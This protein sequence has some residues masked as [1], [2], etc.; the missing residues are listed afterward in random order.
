V[1]NVQ[2]YLSALF[3]AA[4]LPAFAAP[5]TWI[6]V[7][8]PHFE[9]Y[10]TAG[11]RRGRE[12]VQYFEQVREQF[13]RLRSGHTA[14]RR[15]RI[16][17][18]SSKKEFEPYQPT[19]FTPAFY[20]GGEGHDYIVMSALGTENFPVAVH[21]YSH[22]WLKYTGV[23]LPI[24]LNEG[25][26]E[27]HSTLQQ[28]GNR[29]GMGHPI[30]GRLQVLRDQKWLPLARVITVRHGDPEYSEKNRASTFYAQSWLLAHM[31]YLS[32]EFR[33]KWNEFVRGLLENGST[34][35]AFRVAYGK[36]VEEMEKALRRYA[37]GPGMNAMFF[38]GRLEK[39]SEV[40]EV[41]SASPLESGLVLAELL[42][43]M[44]RY[45]RAE[46]I[47]EELA[48]QYPQDAQ[49]AESRGLIAWQNRQLEAAKKHYAQAL[50]LKSTNAKMLVDYGKLVYNEAPDKAVIA[51]QRAVELDASER[52]AH[53]M[54][55]A[56]LFDKRDFAGTVKHLVALK[57]IKP[58]RAFQTYSMLA[59]AQ[60]ETGNKEGA[61]LNAERARKYARGT[62]EVD[63]ADELLRF[64]SDTPRPQPQATAAAH[65][66]EP[67]PAGDPK[68][69]RRAD[70]RPPRSGEPRIFHQEPR[71]S[72]AGTLHQLD[73]MGASARIHVS[74]GQ[75]RL[76]FVIKDPGQVLIKTSEG[77]AT[78]DFT[79]GP[80]KP[81][82]VT[83]EYVPTPDA[84]LGTAGV[85]RVLEFAN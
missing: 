7:T 44:Q 57:E 80:Q 73:C 70:A 46:R 33:P 56:L 78:M 23:D 9:L 61:K 16:V 6:K 38:P 37:A 20:L 66:E 76:T 60:Y 79:C 27:I 18:F 64:V 65:A 48:Q 58:D 24:W 42:G 19:E 84:K 68:L 59:W 63:R 45:D 35:H 30:T 51:L 50:E 55:G 82:K 49:V 29:V 47:Y 34:E 22:L 85:V 10:T 74:A 8:S 1:L 54:L 43:F 31:L 2:H 26:A 40:P 67:E 41:A 52:E 83:V 4:A 11:E 71:E 69:T 21:E 81:R 5:A 36:S 3:L 53:E 28:N 62:V 77:G 32:D 15:I 12:A 72:F 14:T 17:A 25:L 75:R 39:P 13:L